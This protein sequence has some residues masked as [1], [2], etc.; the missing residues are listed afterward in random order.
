MLL[1]LYFIFNDWII[2]YIHTK[3]FTAYIM[4]LKIV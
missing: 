3:N 4:I 2:H 1:K